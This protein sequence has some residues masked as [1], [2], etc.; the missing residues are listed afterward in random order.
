[1]SPQ[2]ASGTIGVL[3]PRDI[4][5]GDLVAFAQEADDYGFG[6]LWV[7]EDLGYRGGLVQA[8]T[9]LA[10]TRRIRVGVG[11]LPAAARNVAFAAMEVATSQV[12]QECRVPLKSQQ[13]IGASTHVNP[14]FPDNHGSATIGRAHQTHQ[15]PPLD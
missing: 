15:R 4:P 3:L 8:A 1:M 7:V 5:Q 14:S 10:H 11:L 12:H 13:E 2:E 9:V 6:E